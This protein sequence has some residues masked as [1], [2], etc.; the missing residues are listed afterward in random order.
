MRARLAQLRWRWRQIPRRTRL[1]VVIAVVAITGLVW[2]HYTAP[3]SCSA[4][5]GQNAAASTEHDHIGHG[6]SDDGEYQPDPAGLA[7]PP[8]FSP[9]AAR[10]TVGRFALNFASPNGNHSDWLARIGSDVMPELLDQYRLTD[11]RNVPQ[12]VVVQVSG[13]MTDNLGAPTFQVSY[14]DGS[15]VEVTLE[16]DV[17]GWKV[18]SVVPVDAPV[19]PSAPVRAQGPR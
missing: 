13:P 15:S 8:D 11:I 4:Q 3:E 9:E 12:A 18:S 6:H 1:G 17:T 5:D 16:M 2:Q 14:G 10:T 7:P 19:G